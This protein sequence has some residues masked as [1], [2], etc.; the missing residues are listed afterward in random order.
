MAAMRALPPAT[1]DPAPEVVE[2]APFELDL[3]EA[4]FT[5]DSALMSSG[6]GAE[7]GG[8]LQD[9]ALAQLM[10]RG[11]AR[12]HNGVTDLSATSCAQSLDAHGTTK[13]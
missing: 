1:Y 2:P 11:R 13:L 7:L 4:V 8:V 9:R 12:S 10:C 6:W 3:M 5:V